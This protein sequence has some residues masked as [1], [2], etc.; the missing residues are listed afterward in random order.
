[1]KAIIIDD[2]KRARLLLKALL[3]DF[4]QEIEV[5]GD[6]VDLETGV[7]AIKKIQPELVFLDIELPEK[8]G[9]QIL[10]YFQKEEV[11]FSIIFVTAYNEYAIQAFKLSA[12]D[13]ILKP[14]NSEKLVEAVQHFK[15][16][17]LKQNR[18]LEALK[19]NLYEVKKK[20]VI[21]NRDGVQF[22]NPEDIKYI[23]G[24]GSY[25]QFNLFEGKRV[26]M[27]RNLKFVE[28]MIAP[29]PFLKRVHK[30]YIVNVNEIS[31]FNRGNGKLI[32]KEGTE[33]Q[34]TSDKMDSIGLKM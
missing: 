34:A 25:C 13:Y 15:N 16:Q 29:F 20:I 6:Y 12:I 22:I 27:S 3:Q 9:L 17:K 28:K 4:C 11:N 7:A 32:L 8:S 18:Q 21:P 10:D 5:L 2:E 24:E 26:L 31:S 30:S 14:I 23:N 1:M 33:L 19:S